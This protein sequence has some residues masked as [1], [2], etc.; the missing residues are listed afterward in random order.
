MSM[1]LMLVAAEG[2]HAR[3]LPMP[4]FMYALIA[5][6]AFVLLLAVTWAFRGMA[7][8][9]GSGTTT[10]GHDTDTTTNPAERH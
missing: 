7:A 10:H 4:P 8:K 2:E 1:S 3:E 5:A 9:Y 6:I